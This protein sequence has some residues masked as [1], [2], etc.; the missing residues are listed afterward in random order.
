MVMR[1]VVQGGTHTFNPT[2]SEQT[3]A[4]QRAADP[5]GAA[6]EWDAEFRTDISTFLD[7]ELIDAAVEHGRPLELPPRPYPAFYRAFTDS[8]GGTGRD[9]YT[10]AI[11]HKEVEHY[12][13]DVV[14]GTRPGQKF[15]PATVTKEYAKLLEEYRIGSVTGDNYAAQW[16][17]GAWRDTGMSYVQSD[18]PKSAIYLECL[19]LFTRGLVRLP[20]HARLLKELRLLERQTHRGGKDSVD[21]PR[22]NH[23]DHANAVCGVL[24]TLSNYLGFSFERMIDDGEENT[25]VRQLSEADQWHQFRLHQYMRS[26][27]IWI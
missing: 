11:A 10:I 21:H 17:Q 3:I 25:A 2:L 19:P 6:S 14:R 1:F 24:R 18:I 4:T 20:D 12:H 9:S 8:A 15:D 22:G 7:D 13:I 27:G 16:V 26:Q 23:D 5:T